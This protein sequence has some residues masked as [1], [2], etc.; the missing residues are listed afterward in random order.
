MLPRLWIALLALLLLAAPAD[1]TLAETVETPSSMSLCDDAAAT[2]VEIPRAAERPH[3]TA[4]A[5]RPEDAVPPAPVL[6]RIF[7]PPRPSLD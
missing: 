5:G 7:R 4:C 1:S 2:P 3:R 6:A